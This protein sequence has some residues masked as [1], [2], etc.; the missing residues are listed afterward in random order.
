MQKTQ[1]TKDSYLDLHEKMIEI[2]DMLKDQIVIAAIQRSY[3]ISDVENLE[4]ISSFIIE[5]ESKSDIGTYV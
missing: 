1:L 2:I 4:K 3:M 5:P